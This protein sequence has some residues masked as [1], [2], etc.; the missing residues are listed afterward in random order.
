MQTKLED[1][2]I[3]LLRNAEVDKI[4]EIGVSAIPA[5]IT[6]LKNKDSNVQE[7]AAKA[8]GKIEINDKQFET[9]LRMLK[10]GETSEERY[11]AAI[12]LGEL[13]NVKAIPALITALK[14]KDSNMRWRAAEAIEKIAKANPNSKEVLEAV[15]A[16]ITALKDVDRG[17]RESAAGAIG[18][19]GV[20]DEQF[21]TIVRMLKEGKTWKERHGAVRALSELKNIKTIPALI[22]ALKDEEIV[23]QWTAAEVIGKIGVNDEQFET[24]IKML[25]EGETKEEREGA[26]TALGEL[27]NVKAVPNLI[28]A[29]KDVNPDVRES[30][31]EAI[32]K[33]GEA[34][35]GN[36]E[37]LE[38]ITALLN[39]LKDKFD[40]VQKRVAEA[41]GKIGVNYEQ[42]ETILRM[43]KKGETSE[44]R[45]GAAIALGALE[46]LKAIPALIT[47]LKDKFE[48]VR[49][50]AAEAIREI[51]EANPGNKEVLEAIPALITALKD[52]DSD[53]RWV[54]AEAIG[55]IGVNDE[56][57]ETIVRMLKE[58]E[59][60]E[61]RYGAVRALSE[62][63][64]VKTIPALITALKD[65]DS[66]VRW[67]A[68]EAIGKIS[69]KLVEEHIKLAEQ[70][71]EKGEF[72]EALKAIRT[73]TITIAKFYED[74]FLMAKKINKTMGKDRYL[75]EK[76]REIL[77][78]LQSLTDRIYEIMQKKMLPNP[79]NEKEPIELKHLKRDDKKSYRH[80]NVLNVLNS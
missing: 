55:K 50:S 65:K 42:F 32:G 39:A 63:K 70:A 60:K 19:I 17:V 23:V 16:L 4:V 44:E 79:L 29:L 54:A 25:K 61:E 58:G 26:A 33:I 38:A 46:N 10:E 59:T 6:A 41:I 2:I 67:V 7:N 77:K 48:Y 73:A 9:I 37:V 20:N 57:F 72:E 3:R 11:G 78:K 13:K 64:N 43:L 12:A 31:A 49:R 22:T 36:K 28:T 34:N 24:I 8:I 69:E 5:L 18:K 30:A 40:Y 35:P 51:A 75:L 80:T 56:Q 45:H 66:D 52:K 14:D 68:A 76:R 74:A 53:V 1:E 27:K 62:L 21:E 47:A 71:I 15:P